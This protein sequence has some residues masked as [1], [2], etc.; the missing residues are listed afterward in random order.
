MNWEAAGAIVVSAVGIAASLAGLVWTVGRILKP[1]MWEA[2]QKACNELYGRLRS[3]D[4][5]HVEEAV[6]AIAE[7]MERIESRMGEQMAQIRERMD[8]NEIQSREQLEQ[9]AQIRERMDRNESRRREE[10][11][12]MEARILAALAGL[13]ASPTQ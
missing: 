10:A 4:F 6:R 1:W 11:A 8:R 13:Q 12:A 7:R 5:H 3:N 9:M 2:S